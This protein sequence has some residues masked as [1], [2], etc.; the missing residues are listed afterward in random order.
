[1]NWID[2]P[3]TRSRI[4]TSVE[5]YLTKDALGWPHLERILA[6][7]RKKTAKFTL[8]Y[9]ATTEDDF[10][11]K[12]TVKSLSYKDGSKLKQTNFHYIKY[13]Q[14]KISDQELFFPDGSGYAAMDFRF[15]APGKS[16]ESVYFFIKDYGKT[17]WVFPY[18]TSKSKPKKRW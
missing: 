14:V 5:K 6:N 16:W 2:C 18:D 8:L 11:K 3:I 17:W 9:K 7:T 1:M 12:L 4:E 15:N 10:N 13:K